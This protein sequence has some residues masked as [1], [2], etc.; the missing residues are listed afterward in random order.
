MNFLNKI[1]V[2]GLCAIILCINITVVEGAWKQSSNNWWYSDDN[3]VGYVT[4]WK[5][6]DN[7]WY[8]FD[9]SGFMKTGW[10]NYNGSWY[11][12]HTQGNM[13]HDC[14]IEGYYINS[15]GVWT[16]EFKDNEKEFFIENKNKGIK[17]ENLREDLTVY[18][19][20]S[21][22]KYHQKNN[23]LELNPRKILKTTLAEAGAM[24]FEKC[25]ICWN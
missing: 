10:L 20:G 25:N 18:L 11:Y 22:A 24:G 8:Y 21:E 12:F 19:S 15:N 3:A 2:L 23:C 9:N 5:N 1:S 7:D 16:N 13:A 17:C 14:Y 4:G 6:I